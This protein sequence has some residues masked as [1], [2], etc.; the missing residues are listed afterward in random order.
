MLKIGLTGGIASGKSL[1]ASRLRELGAI[2]VDADHLAR[3]VVK[4]G[5]PGLARVVDAFGPGILDSQ[6]ELD[7]PKLGAIVF[8]DP[9]QRE[10]L[11]GI[12]HP[13]VRE[14]AAAMVANAGPEDIVVQ[15]IPLLVETGQGRNFHLVVVVDAPD[16]IRIQRMVEFRRM[17]T[18]EA[19]ARMASQATRAER[20]AAADVVLDN[21]GTRERL[22]AAVDTLWEHR[23]V[24]LANSLHHSSGA[25]RDT[26]SVSPH[27]PITPSG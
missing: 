19:M 6:G 3:E 14:A 26:G 4:P 22:L 25:P 11:N 18:E 2:L 21:S 1:V 27:N 8:K 23:L 9:S 17:T 10:V 20:N 15:D 24:P 5:T 13:L 7:R 12:V 16:D